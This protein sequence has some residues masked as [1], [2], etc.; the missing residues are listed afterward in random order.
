MCAKFFLV[1]CVLLNIAQADM[2]RKCVHNVFLWKIDGIF[3]ENHLK[4]AQQGVLEERGG[5]RTGRSNRFVGK[6]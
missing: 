1:L 4:I 2:F 6:C 5:Q 3:K